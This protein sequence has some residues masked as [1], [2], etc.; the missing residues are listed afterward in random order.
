[1]KY[2]EYALAHPKH[3]NVV[4]EAKE[5]FSL[6]RAKG[7]NIPIFRSVFN[8]DEG[9]LA[10]IKEKKTVKG[11]EGKKY[12][13]NI[14]IDIDKGS[15]SDNYTLL[16]L[17]NV[18]DKLDD[19]GLA[20]SSYI[21][22]FSGTG[23]H[24][25]ITNKEFLF[26]PDPDLPVRVEATMKALGLCEDVSV[27]KKTALI[28]APHTLNMKSNLYKVPLTYEEATSLNVEDIHALART[29]RLD[30]PYERITG[31][32]LFVGKVVEVDKQMPEKTRIYNY[33]KTAH[34][35][36]YVCMQ[37]LLNDGPQEGTR[38]NSI[39]RL[40]SHLKWSGIPED[41]AKNIAVYW[42]NK[43]EQSLDEDTLLQK[44][45]YVYNSAVKYGCR[46]FI[47]KE[48]C[49]PSCK[50]FKDRNQEGDIDPLSI[51]SLRDHFHERV[52]L[53]E[54]KHTFINLRN[55]F[56]LD[57]DC[58]LRPGE[59]VT[60]QGDTG[61]NKTS[62]VQ[63]ILL[64]FNMVNQT[65][66]PHKKNILLY[67]TEL[68]GGGIYER[69]LAILSGKTPAQLHANPQISDQY[70][71][72][73][74]NFSLQAGPIT[75]EGIESIISKYQYEVIVID[76]LEKIVHP[77]F[78][79]GMDTAA[80]S[81]IMK[82]LSN[83]AQKYNIVIIAISQVSRSQVTNGAKVGLHSGKGSSTIEQSSRRVITINGDQKSPY[84]Q[85]EQVK[86]NDDDPWGP[87]TIERL[88]SWRFARR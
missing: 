4:L 41:F 29:Q 2:I 52:A 72:H 19:Y 50:Y 15:N 55:I 33:D 3:R 49:R 85:L 77:L 45:V 36:H 7:R 16:K 82:S 69:N 28:R 83:M 48:Y 40:A 68:G 64:G 35:M 86:A 30:F 20:P 51:D 79:R 88:G 59:V 76:Y 63:N 27:Y 5:L 32:G 54:Q 84:R 10:Q 37:K 11:Y 70:K 53:M 1:M 75:V 38:N 61:C 12:I 66:H 43:T 13:M 74:R 73:M 58:Y 9:I 62:I 78:D 14:P 23:Y 22:Y 80:L 39:L 25:H 71:D 24:V 47:M 6:I 34:L 56:G 17:R 8:Y 57:K 18:L 44:V 60:F 42:N 67:E 46:D 31:E 65:F 87:I 26:E 81:S 21:I